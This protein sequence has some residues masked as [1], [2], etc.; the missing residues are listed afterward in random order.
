MHPERRDLD[1]DWRDLLRRSSLPALLALVVFV[2]LANSSGLLSSNDGSHLA[3]ARALVL[4]GHTQIDPDRGL[5]LEVDLAQRGGHAY[6]DRPPGTAFAALPG[7]WIGDRLD[8]PMFERAMRQVQAKRDVDP[9]PAAGPYIATYAKRTAGGAVAGPRLAQLIGTSLAI[10]IHAALVGVVGLLLLA[11]SLRR[12]GAPAAGLGPR[13]FALAC[14]GLASAWGPY[15]SALFSHVSAATAV[16]GFLLGVVVLATARDQARSRRT[17]AAVAALTGLAGAWAISCDYL[18]LLAIVPA[19][20]L[21]IQVR[22]WPAVL[23]GTIPIVV[24]TLAYHHAAF[25]GVFEVG[26]DHQQNFEFARERGT[27]F[28]GNFFDGVWTL[29][30]LGRGAGLLAQSPITLVGL[31]ALPVIAWRERDSNDASSRTQITA[32][33][34]LLGFVPWVVV[35]A[36]HR[37]PWGGNTEDHRYLIPLLPFAALGLGLAWARASPLVHGALVALALASAFLVWRPFLAW[38][39]TPAFDR[40]ALGAAAAALVLGVAAVVAGIRAGIGAGPAALRR[41]LRAGPASW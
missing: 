28:S 18:L 37:T 35:L 6:S 1:S 30:G 15:S 27:T 14:L 33:R 16:A 13:L 12:F 4:R 7:V 3:L 5:T 8:P 25:G 26:Y 29:W 36:L 23:V 10:S 20:L 22:A 31:L 17:L 24:A 32:A 9:L 39:E 2:W 38:H 21:A 19:S 11:A 41:K 34:A 40:P